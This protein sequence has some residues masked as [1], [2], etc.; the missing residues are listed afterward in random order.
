M[1]VYDQIYN[2]CVVCLSFCPRVMVFFTK[3]SN[4]FFTLTACLL[5]IYMQFLRI[6]NSVV[7]LHMLSMQTFF[8]GDFG[9][10]ISFHGIAILRC[11]ENHRKQNSK[12]RRNTI[13]GL[14]WFSMV[15]MVE[16]GFLWFLYMVEYG[17][18]CFHGFENYGHHSSHNSS[19]HE[20]QNPLPF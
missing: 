3:V 6:F 1:K 10:G 14:L 11:I 7:V 2:P 17:F 9:L 18:L 13:Y 12:R 16:Y 5:Y 20:T 4:I 8:C 19:T 15:S